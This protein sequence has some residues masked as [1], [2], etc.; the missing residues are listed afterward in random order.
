LS[1]IKV[2]WRLSAYRPIVAEPEPIQPARRCSR[3][4]KPARLRSTFIDPFAKRRMRLFECDSC[5][6]LEAAVMEP[7]NP[8]GDT[9]G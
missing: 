8:P 7:G 3:C 2:S 6:K 9:E 5:G 1:G 4:G